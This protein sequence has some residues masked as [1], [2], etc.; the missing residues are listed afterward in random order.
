MRG[1]DTL[2]QLIVVLVSAATMADFG[3][4]AECLLRARGDGH[5]ATR[6]CLRWGGR[7]L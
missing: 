3:S 7:G 4:E 6:L 2:T 1:I 5:T